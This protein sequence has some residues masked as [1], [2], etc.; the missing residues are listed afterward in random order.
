MPD[1]RALRAACDDSE[2]HF[3][4]QS[5]LRFL[6]RRRNS[7]VAFVIPPGVAFGL[8]DRWYR[9]VWENIRQG[10]LT[11]G[12]HVVIQLHPAPITL[13]SIRSSNRGQQRT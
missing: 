5:R 12:R 1:A 2:G 6:N 8:A 11:L 13:P 9:P 3:I 7:A 4:L 10:G